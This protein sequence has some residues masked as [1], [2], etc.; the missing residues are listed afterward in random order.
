[1]N[2]FSKRN[3]VILVIAV[4]LIINIAS[5]STI[6]Y[7]SYGNRINKM[8]E[9]ERTSMRDFRQE[10]N[11]NA[12]QIDEFGKL[13]KKFM[14]DTRMRMDE[15]HQI[16]LALINEM[17]SAN[18]DTAKMFAMADDIGKLHAQI[19]RQTIDHFLI[20]KNNCTDAQFDKFV[21]LFQRS[22]MDDNYSRWSEV[23]GRGKNYRSR[24]I[25]RGKGN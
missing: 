6:V 15:M 19:K 23:Q 20:I 17:S 25:Q 1:M 13:G 3:I 9:T 2:Y 24:N 18:P 21:T 8:P 5:I 12:Q 14:I 16:R 7:H 10:L 4:L 11:L 22:L